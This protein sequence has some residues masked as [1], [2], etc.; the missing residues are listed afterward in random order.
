MLRGRAAQ[1]LADAFERVVG[2]DREAL[3]RG[4]VLAWLPWASVRSVSLA[5]AE[6]SWEVSLHAEV[7]VAG[8][9]EREAGGLR[10][11]GIEP[12]HF[13]FPHGGVSTLAT[14]FASRADRT[15]ALAIARGARYQ[16]HRRVVLPAGA[17]VARAADPLDAHDARLDAARTGA[18]ADGAL[19][20]TFTLS[21]P[22]GTVP[23]D[24]YVAFA[25]LLR[26]VD[27]AFLASTRVAL[28]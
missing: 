21:L 15:S 16:V 22:T 3:L 27:D 4:A 8:F 11:P 20:E 18:V 14:I 24:A 7:D 10:L 25:A 13:V 19:D 17:R 2:A 28:P 1:G 12:L 6:G 9:A 5:S 26:R 23:P